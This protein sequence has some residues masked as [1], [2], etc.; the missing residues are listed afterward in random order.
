MIVSVPSAHYNFP[1]LENLHDP[2]D[3]RTLEARFR[4]LVHRVVSVP[5]TRI[6]EIREL[7]KK[8]KA[9]SRPRRASK[10]VAS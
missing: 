8:A 7:E 5:K 4:D 3:K 9:N 2:N 1:M 10:P 6:D